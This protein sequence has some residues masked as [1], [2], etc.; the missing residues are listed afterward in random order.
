VIR[1]HCCDFI[2][3]VMTNEDTDWNLEKTHGLSPVVD[4]Y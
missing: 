1:I 4:V 3:S 2:C